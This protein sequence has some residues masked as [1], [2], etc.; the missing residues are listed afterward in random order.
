MKQSPLRLLAF[1]LGMAGVLVA[2][3]AAAVAFGYFPGWAADNLNPGELGSISALAIAAAIGCAYA[4][5]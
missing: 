1:L 3:L 4:A 2:V 5:R